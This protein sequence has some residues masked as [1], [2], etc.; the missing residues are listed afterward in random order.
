MSTFSVGLRHVDTV[1]VMDLRGF[2][3]AHTAAE[4]ER[5]FQQLL[6]EK[7]YKI[8]VN[9]RDLVYISSAGLGVFMEFIEDIRRNQGDIKLSNMS[10]KVFHVFDLVGFPQLYDIMKDE[11]DAVRKFTGRT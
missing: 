6:Q 10:P 5:A 4:L 2:L 3:D 8:V 11:G 1:S 9:F 7:K